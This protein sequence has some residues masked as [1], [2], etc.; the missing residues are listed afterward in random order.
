MARNG[1]IILARGIGMDKEHKNIIIPIGSTGYAAKAIYDDV[2]KNIKDYPYLEK[3][4]GQLG[5]ET[6]TNA[7][8]TIVKRIMRDVDNC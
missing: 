8:V 2:V 5:Y 4:I 6:D 3:Y 1:N 7:I